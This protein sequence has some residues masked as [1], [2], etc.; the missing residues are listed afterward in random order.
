MA[1]LTLRP[2]THDEAL[3]VILGAVQAWRDGR[4]SPAEALADIGGAL[5]ASGDGG[6]RRV[7]GGL[8]AG[9]ASR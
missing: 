7:P 3:Q 4:I 2:L 6:S 5:E 9:P 1:K 8:D